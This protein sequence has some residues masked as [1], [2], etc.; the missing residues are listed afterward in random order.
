MGSQLYTI[1]TNGGES[2]NRMSTN[3][4]DETTYEKLYLS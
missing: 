3:D 2:N 1:A 4:N